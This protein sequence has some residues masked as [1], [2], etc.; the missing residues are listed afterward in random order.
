[1]NALLQKK[2]P[3]NRWRR[4]QAERNRFLPVALFFIAVLFYLPVLAQNNIRVQGKVTDEAGQPVG[5]ASISVKGTNIGTNADD[6]GSFTILAPSNG[7]LV[8]SSVSF[9]TQ[10]VKI[11]NRP[12]LE[13]TLKTSTIMEGEVVVIG[14][15][16]VRKKDVTGSTVTVKGET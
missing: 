6:K 3:G 10:E 16:A 14:Y 7:I 5:G 9:A 2:I 4:D 1:M 15:G 8:F 12:V 13:V 11:N